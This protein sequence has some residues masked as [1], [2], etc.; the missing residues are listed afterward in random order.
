MTDMRVPFNI[1]N[2]T[3]CL[4]P[5][6][7]MQAESDCVSSSESAWSE[8][9]K[10]VGHILM[11]YPDHPETYELE[12]EKL[13]RH[14]AARRHGFTTP[15]RDTMRE[16]FCSIGKSAC[17]DLAEGVRCICSDC[18]VWSQHELRRMYFCLQ[19]TGE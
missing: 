10:L 2:Y 9:H 6:C 11:E 16:L 19:G 12:V 18:A 1:S 3:K 5:V 7:P 15:Q 14:E 4:C 13:E 17:D 8:A